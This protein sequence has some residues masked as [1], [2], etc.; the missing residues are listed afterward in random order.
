MV[1][2]G[3]AEEDK[4]VNGD[5]TADA[6]FA[7]S[8]RQFARESVKETDAI[9]LQVLDDAVAAPVPLGSMSLWIA[10][11]HIGCV[12]DLPPQYLVAFIGRI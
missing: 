2:F 12:I 4:V 11:D 1:V 8:H 7:D 10:E 5:D 9:A 6:R 3:M